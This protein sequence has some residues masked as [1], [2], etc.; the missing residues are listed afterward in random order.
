MRKLIIFED[1]L[2]EPVTTT[3]DFDPDRRIVPDNEEV[4]SVAIATDTIISLTETRDG[5]NVITV[6]S[7]EYDIFSNNPSKLFFEIC[8][9]IT[10]ESGSMMDIV[11]L[12]L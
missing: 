1:R 4:R 8:K 5:V 7:G 6:D 3:E 9:F 12:D 2:R 11:N 10:T